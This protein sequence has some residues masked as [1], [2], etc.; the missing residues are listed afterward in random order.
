MLQGGCACGS[1]RFEIDAVRALTHCHCTICRKLTGASFA[2]Y[3]HVEKSKFRWL[4]GQKTIRRYE[5]APGSFRAF[6]PKCS[7]L[8]PGQATYL[9]TISV[10]A[11]LLEGD[12]GVRPRL[13]V[14]ASSKAP[15]WEIA[16]DLP[17]YA[18]W[19]TGYEPQPINPRAAKRPKKKRA[20]TKKKP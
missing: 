17:Q 12:P 11:G 2:T 20:T 8:V 10:P 6:C 3:A 13:H 5:S 1:V 19:V 4:G 16:D 18:T 7:S 9:E 15:W 14:F